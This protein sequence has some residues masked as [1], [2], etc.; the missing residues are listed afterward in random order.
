MTPDRTGKLFSLY[1]R[2]Q[3][4][5]GA[6]SLV[7]IAG[8]PPRVSTVAIAALS[9]TDSR[10]PILADDEWDEYCV[11]INYLNCAIDLKTLDRKQLGAAHLT[12]LIG[13]E[14]TFHN[15]QRLGMAEATWILAT[16]SRLLGDDYTETTAAY[17][18]SSLKCIHRPNEELTFCHLAVAVLRGDHV[19]KCLRQCAAATRHAAASGVFQVAPAQTGNAAW[20]DLMTDLEP[21]VLA[22]IDALVDIRRALGAFAGSREVEMRRRIA[23]RRVNTTRTSAPEP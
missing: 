12:G 3:A 7:A 20:R 14:N 5:D 18:E 16:T 8:P 15:E 9:M 21:D 2:D 13:L 19:V 6:P 11:L 22:V 1:H 4:V 23:S 10:A 17:I